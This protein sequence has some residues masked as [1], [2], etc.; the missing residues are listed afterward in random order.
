MSTIKVEVTRISDVRPHANADALEL[1][2]V[3]GWQVCV[4]K[5][6]YRD[7][8]PVVYF[9]QDTVLP[10]EI[11]DRLG[12]TQ[13]MKERVDIDGQRVLI[14]HRV[15]LRG[16][17]SFGLVIPPEP[18]LEVGDDVA[19]FYGAVKYEPPLRTTAG[20]AAPSDPRF[21][22]YT[23]IEN[24]RSYPETIFE[25]EEVVAT[26]K[27][28]GTNC[29]VGFVVD[30]VD[31]ERIYRPMAGSKGMGR[32]EPPDRDAARLNTYWYPT[33]LPGVESLLGELF[34]QGRRQAVLYGEVYGQGIQS[35]TYG[36]KGV[37]FRAFD[38]MIDGQFLDYPDFVDLCEKHGVE[39]T[40]LVY[41]GPF[42]LSIL[43]RVSEGDSLVGGAHGREGV[44]V[45]PVRERQDVKIGR[46]V[47][48][49]I[50]DA[51]LFGKAG[52]QETTDL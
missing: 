50:G 46:V 17:P 16:E 49:Y 7:G 41:R 43:K 29:R 26:E 21:P 22:A 14:I 31:G 27:V 39:M 6:V 34:A 25:G 24:M 44:V 48:K 18:G 52:E 9:E 11:A 28:H 40:P 38:L 45:K 23:D 20:D 2:T 13:Y 19:G 10:R 8:D 42:S 1:A 51:Y 47:L 12:V 33:T 36:E 15:R 35:Y 30:V 37:A 4:K 32:K 3:G 5:G